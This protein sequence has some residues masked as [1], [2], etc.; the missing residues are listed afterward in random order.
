MFLAFFLILVMFVLDAVIALLVSVAGG[1][2]MQ[3]AVNAWIDNLQLPIEP[4]DYPS[5]F[6]LLFTLSL[7][8]VL[9]RTVVSVS[10]GIQ[11]EIV[12]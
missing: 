2:V 1:W 8:V 6:V 12:S 5:G 4:I 9:I 11:K 3:W 10:D 7:V